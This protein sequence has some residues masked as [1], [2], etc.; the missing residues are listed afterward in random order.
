MLSSHLLLTSQR[1]HS[2]HVCRFVE[3]KAPYFECA[4]LV[5]RLILTGMPWWW[6]LPLGCLQSARY[7]RDHLYSARIRKPSDF[8][9]LLLFH[10]FLFPHFSERLHRQGRGEI[11]NSEHGATLSICLMVVC[12]ACPSFSG[13]C[14]WHSAWWNCNQVQGRCWRPVW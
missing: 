13:Q 7:R 11:A 4:E 8:C 2:H 1:I 9:T 5:R 12:E 10:F 3:D 14:Q 6:V